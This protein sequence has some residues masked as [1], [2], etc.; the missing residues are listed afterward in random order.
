M[1]R[2]KVA[3][4]IPAF[5]EELTISKIVKVASIYGEVIVV[6][7]CSSDLTGKK[8]KNAGASVV[9][10]NLNLGYDSAL[11]TG[12]KKAAENKCDFIITLDADGQHRP[13]LLVKF[14]DLLYKGTPMVLGVR[15]SKARIGEHIFSFYTKHF[16][17]VLDP[18]CGLKGFRRKDYEEV[19]HFDSYNSIGT[20]LMLRNI[21][22]N[23]SFKQVFFQVKARTDKSRLGNSIIVNI[24]IFRS[25]IIWLLKKNKGKYN[26][27]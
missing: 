24:R 26:F 2:S 5:N 15:N 27:K 18:L 12:F 19:G 11:N 16:Y 6:D 13:E 8:A 25:L 10:H 14:I 21:N 22:S 17:G 23:L 9:T 4:V 1:D 20:E 3:I 7:D